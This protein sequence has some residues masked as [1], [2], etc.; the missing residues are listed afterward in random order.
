MS[1]N[2]RAELAERIHSAIR[3]ISLY[4]A[5]EAGT[6]RPAYTTPWRAAMDEVSSWFVQ[7]GLSIRRDAVGNLFGRAEGTATDRHVILTGSH[8]DSIVGGGDYDGVAGVVCSFVALTTLL[9][10]RG[11]PRRT[12]ELVAIADEESSRFKSSFWGARAIVG[13]IR[14]EELDKLQDADGVT[15]RAA[16][17]EAGLPNPDLAA[18][19]RDDIAAFLELHIEQG[20]VLESDGLAVG[21][22]TGITGAHWSD[23]TITGVSNHAGGTPMSHRKD[24]MPAAAE[25]IERVELIA[26]EFGDPARGTVGRVAVTPGAANAIPASV[27]FSADLRH[28]DP[29]QYRALIERA[30]RDFRAIAERRQVG[31]QSTTY[32]DEVPTPM[33]PQ[34]VA[35]L[36]EA[37]SKLGL[38]DRLLSSGGGHDSMIMARHGIPT[39]MIF[40]RCRG[41]VSHSPEEFAADDDLAAGTAVLVETLKRL[42]Y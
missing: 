27:T 9:R 4:G 6:V 41:G 31:L 24:P 25:M 15:V 3:S 2:N 20:P 10:T 40:V 38:G 21:V 23:H 34:L 5:T 36:R 7:A 22:V 13:R 18:C 32:I 11:R 14:E 19:R 12:V 26:N 37:A 42:A 17:R 8:L 30:F 33:A 28:P 1:E 29:A 35:S 39:G 16:I